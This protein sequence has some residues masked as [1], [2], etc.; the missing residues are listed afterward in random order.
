M[1]IT[2]VLLFFVFVVRVL[3]CQSFFEAGTGRVLYTPEIHQG[4]FDVWYQGYQ[5]DH[6]KPWHYQ[7]S[8]QF[9]LPLGGFAQNGRPYGMMAYMT[10]PRLTF[11]NYDIYGNEVA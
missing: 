10:R 9:G 11:K 2:S 8:P 4:Y 3:R 5:N 7:G 1:K 6:P